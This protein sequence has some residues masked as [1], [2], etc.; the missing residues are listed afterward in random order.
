L[1]DSAE[2][3]ALNQALLHTAHEAEH[4]RRTAILN[5]RTPHAIPVI[6]RHF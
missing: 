4:W 5:P 1:R 6:Y 3:G 2:L